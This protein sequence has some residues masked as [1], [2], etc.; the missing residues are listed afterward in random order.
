MSMSPFMG[1]PKKNIETHDLIKTGDPEIGDDN[2]SR[3]P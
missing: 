1:K 2:P 3:Q